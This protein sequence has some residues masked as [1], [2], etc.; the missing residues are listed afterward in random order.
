MS[1]CPC[2]DLL[3]AMGDKSVPNDGFT[4]QRIFPLV[5]ATTLHWVGTSLFFRF[6][7]VLCTALCSALCFAAL[8][9][10]VARQAGACLACQVNLSPSP[11]V[12]PAESR[13]EGLAA[14][15]SG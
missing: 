1:A 8:L 7:S 4:A 11:P 9:A 3:W 2:A 10:G 14:R 15:C 6:T 12:W 5:S 13:L